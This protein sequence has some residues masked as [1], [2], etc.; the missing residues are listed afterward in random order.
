MASIISFED[1]ANL[2]TGRTTYTQDAYEAVVDDFLTQTIEVED[3]KGA[4]TEV[5]VPA[6]GQL[7]AD[8]PAVKPAHVAHKIRNYLKD[9][10]L[11][12]QATVG[13]SPEHGVYLKRTV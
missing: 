9:A 2:K 1:A 11:L 6:L 12:D 13:I 3:E 5:L 4:K 10:D 7:Q 8:F